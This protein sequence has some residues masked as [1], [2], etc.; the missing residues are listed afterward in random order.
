[1]TAPTDQPA[2]QDSWTADDDTAVQALS[3]GWYQASRGV[4][5]ATFTDALA[6]IRAEHGHPH[7]DETGA[8]MTAWWAA[9]GYQDRCDHGGMLR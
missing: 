2:S 6:R 3:W 1:M 8:C 7:D 4:D 5:V 9:Q